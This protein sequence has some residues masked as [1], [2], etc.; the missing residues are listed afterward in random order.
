MRNLINMWAVTILVMVAASCT[1]AFDNSPSEWAE[2]GWNAGI[3]AGTVDGYP[4]GS[5]RPREV[6]TREEAQA[7]AREEAHQ[8]VL[9]GGNVSAGETGE[10]GGSPMTALYIIGAVIAA[11]MIWNAIN[12]V[13]AAGRNNNVAPAAVTPP[14]PAVGEA[15]GAAAIATTAV[16]LN[17]LAGQYGGVR[18]G[19][20]APGGVAV[21][22]SANGLALPGGANGNSPAL[23]AALQA[24]VQQGLVNPNLAGGGTGGAGNPI[25]QSAQGPMTTALQALNPPPTDMAAAT[26]AM[27]A[28][29][30]AAGIDPQ[31][32]DPGAL[33]TLATNL[34][35]AG[36][37]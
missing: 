33:A 17:D 27:F 23:L 34:R 37:I 11:A 25:P 7:F 29:F 6:A 4:D 16:L 14:A 36:Q 26:R 32:P 8:A 24:A 35:A 22:A 5:Y 12:G 31:N 13:I 10:K 30:P 2:A 19:A 3:K 9:E 20:T 28:A 1:S 18:V 21:T 15:N